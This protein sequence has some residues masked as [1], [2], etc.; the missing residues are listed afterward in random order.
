MTEL[1]KKQIF[2]QVKANEHG[3]KDM[4]VEIITNEIY[5][6]LNEIFT[7]EQI[8]LIASKLGGE[9]KSIVDALIP[10]V[11]EYEQKIDAEIN[12]QIGRLVQVLSQN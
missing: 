10:I 8:E 11:E 12:V 4:H 1:I 2:D 7:P 5:R 3:V 9:F 6:Q